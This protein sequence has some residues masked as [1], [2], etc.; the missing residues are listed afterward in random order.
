[1]RSDTA[2]L[3]M[4]TGILCLY[5]TGCASSSTV[6]P[7]GSGYQD[8]TYTYDSFSEPQAHQIT[9]QYRMP[10]R[11]RIKGRQ[12]K[13]WPSLMSSVVVRDD[14]AV[15]IG[16]PRPELFAVR[17]PEPPLQIS[18]QVVALAAK[19]RG[20]SVS[21]LPVSTQLGSLKRT[22]TG[23]EVSVIWGPEWAD[24]V[25]KLRW[26]QIADIMGDV[27]ENGVTNKD[28]AL[29]IVNGLRPGLQR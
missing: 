16:G 14:V 6:E 24:P 25:I 9:L 20:V 29:H 10:N 1:M 13:I 15:F 21:R 5:L 17:A 3:L 4:G 22:D 26:E 23:I 18:D 27:R 28:P 8:V 12:I 19:D 2:A 7:L 11:G